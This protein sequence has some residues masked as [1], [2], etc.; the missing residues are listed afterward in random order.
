MLKTK[1]QR[2]LLACYNSVHPRRIY[3]IENIPKGGAVLVC[4][5]FSA[6]D[7][8]VVFNTCGKEAYFLAKKELFKNKL[9]AKFLTSFGAIP[10]DR[11]NPDIKTMLNSIKLLKQGSKLAIYPEGTRNKYPKKVVLQE[12]KGGSA[13]FA[14]KAK[15]PIVPIMMLKKARMFR[16]TYAMVG[17][18]FELTDYYDKKIT[19]IEI[20]EMDD[21]VREKMLSTLYSLQEKVI[22]KEKC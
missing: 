13:L 14:V 8:G 11:D 6:F 15:V 19:S 7:C 1:F 3:G 4:N 17:A 12:L 9:F 20:K 2:F 10:I 22:N 5:H 18:P 16:R 21:I